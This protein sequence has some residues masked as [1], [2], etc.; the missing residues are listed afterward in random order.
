MTIAEKEAQ[1]II[2]MLTKFG[3]RL[4]SKNLAH[5]C[6]NQIVYYAYKNYGSPNMKMNDLMRRIFE[7]LDEYKIL[8]KMFWVPSALMQADQP[9]RVVCMN[10]EFLPKPNFQMVCS[11]LDFKPN[12]DAMA[13]KYNRLTKKY[14]TAR[15]IGQDQDCIF[16]DFFAAPPSLIKQYRPIIFPPKNANTKTL[17]YVYENLMDVDA[18]LLIRVVSEYPMGIEPFFTD[19]RVKIAEWKKPITFFPSSKRQ[20]IDGYEFLGSRNNLQGVLLLIKIN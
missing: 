10:E 1:A 17:V 20:N 11:F 8:L 14:I 19:K 3:P 18:L 9:S 15:P 2:L 4:K 16:V 12:L 7:L 5:F 13:T 6:D